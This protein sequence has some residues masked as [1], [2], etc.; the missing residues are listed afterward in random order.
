MLAGPDSRTS[1][2]KIRFLD[3]ASRHVFLPLPVIVRSSTIAI[4]KHFIAY[5]NRAGMGFAANASDS[6][7]VHTNLH[8]DYLMNQTIWMFEGIGCN[9]VHVGVGFV[10]DEVDWSD[11]TMNIQFPYVTTFC[12]SIGPSVMPPEV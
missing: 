12:R 2:Q 1:V 4:M 5:H 3:R 11:R 9:G 8:V 10:I 7:S 6:L